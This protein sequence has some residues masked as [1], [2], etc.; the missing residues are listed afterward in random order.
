MNL[1]DDAESIEDFI[2]IHSNVGHR[3]LLFYENGMNLLF[4]AGVV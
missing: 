1:F 2:Q 3:D 4:Y